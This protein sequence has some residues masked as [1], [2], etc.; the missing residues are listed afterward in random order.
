MYRQIL[1]LPY[2]RKYQHIFWRPSPLEELKEYELKTVT[3][4][5][6]CAPFLALR[7]LRDIVDQECYNLSKVKDGLQ[8]QTYVDD[9]CVGADSVSELLT[10]QSD[11]KGVLDRAGLK[12]KKWSSNSSEVML[13]VNPEDRVTNAVSFDVNGGDVVKVLGLQW[14]SNRDVFGFHSKSLPSVL[15]YQ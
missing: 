4:G 12:L 1:V 13:A 15:S 3:Y 14:H 5:I 9:I 10:L 2:Y 11:L 6:N 8:R 7:V